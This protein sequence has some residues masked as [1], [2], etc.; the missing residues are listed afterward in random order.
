MNKYKHPL[1]WAVKTI[2]EQQQQIDRLEAIVDKLTADIELL[3]K[4]KANKRGR[5]AIKQ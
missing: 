1:Q 5:P 4:T 2:D 3:A